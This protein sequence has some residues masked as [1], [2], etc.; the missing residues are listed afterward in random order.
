MM[1]RVDQLIY[2]FI[3]DRIWRW[4][5]AKSIWSSDEKGWIHYYLQTKFFTWN[6][7]NAVRWKGLEKFLPD[8]KKIL[9]AGKDLMIIIEIKEKSN[10]TKRR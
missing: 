3:I 8:Y 2:G 9:S 6:E 4:N 1:E 10:K 7:N 5:F